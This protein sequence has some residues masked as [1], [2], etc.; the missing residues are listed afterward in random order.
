M[1]A[2]QMCRA[3]LRTSM[4]AGVALAACVGSAAA[5]ETRVTQQD[6]TAVAVTIYNENLALVKDRRKV[7]IDPGAQGLAFVDVSA[8]M[9]PETALLH[10]DGGKLGV[11]EQ[12]FEFDL[13]TP[14]KLLEES[15]DET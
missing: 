4:L 11:L 9:R 15:V 2:G 14:E 8:Q 5:Q 10:S 3:G 1:K 6:Q 13:L 7:Q 12:N